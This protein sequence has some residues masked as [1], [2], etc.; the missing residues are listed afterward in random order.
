ME[1]KKSLFALSSEKA[2]NLLKKIHW[3]NYPNASTA[4]LG[5]STDGCMC[6]SVHNLSLREDEGIKYLVSKKV[7]LLLTLDT[8]VN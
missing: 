3:Q 2:K 8:R 7:F 5:G 4:R 1:M 6:I